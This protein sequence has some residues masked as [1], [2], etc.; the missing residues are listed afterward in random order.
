MQFKD[1]FIIKNY[2]IC[3]EWSY[4]KVVASW[5][6]DGNNTN[7]CVWDGVECNQDT[8]HVIA[9]NLESNCLY[10]SITSSS[11]LLCLLHLQNLTLAY[12]DFNHSQ[13]PS[14]IGNLSSLIHLDLSYSKFSGQIPFEIQYLSKLSFLY[15]VS[16]D[17]YNLYT[18]SLMKSLVQNLT[19][20]E[21]LRFSDLGSYRLYGRF[22]TRIFQLPH[23]LG[24]SA[25]YNEDLTGHLPKFH[26]NS[27]LK[28][29]ILGGTNFSGDLP[30]SIG[31]L[32]SLN[33]FK[34]GNC[35][36]LGTIP[37]SFSNLTHLIELDLSQNSFDDLSWLTRAKLSHLN[38]TKFPDILRNQSRLWYLDLKGNNF[39]G[40]IPKWMFNPECG[41]LKLNVDGSSMGNPGAAGA[42]GVLRDSKGDLLMAFSVHLGTGS[43]NY[44]E[45][46]SLIHGLRRIKMMG[47][48][49][50]DLESDSMMVVRWLKASRCEVWYL[51]EFWEELMEMLKEIEFQ[52]SHIYREGNVAA[53]FLARLGAKGLNKQWL[54]RDI[55]SNLRGIL[56]MDKLE[57]LGR[58]YLSNNFLSGIENSPTIIPWPKLEDLELKNNMMHGSLPIPPPAIWFYSISNNSFTGRISPFICNMSSPLLLDLSYNHLSCMIHPCI[59]NLSQS[60]SV[61]V[62][63]SNNFSSNIP[64]TCQNQ[65]QG[66]LPRSLANCTKHEY[67]HVGHNQINDTYPFWLGTL[68]QL[69]ILVFHSNGFHD[70][71]R[72]PE[73]NYTLPNL[74]IIDLSDNHLSRNLPPGYFTQWDA[75]KSVGAKNLKYLDDYSIDCS[76]IITT[77]GVELEYKKIQDGLTVIDFSCNRFEEDILERLGNLVGLLVLNLSNNAFTGHIPSSFANLTQLESL[78]LS[79][80]KLFG[81]IPPDLTHLNFLSKFNVSHNCLIGLI[82]HGQQFGTFGNTSFEDNRALCGRPLSKIYGD[83]DNS[84]P[85]PSTNFEENQGPK[86]FFEFGWKAVVMGYGCGFVFGVV[87]GHIVITRKQD[88]VI[89]IFGK[90]QHQ[91]RIMVNHRK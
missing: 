25:L 1:S 77:K 47:V 60:L 80:N 73:T 79:Q 35:N 50:I 6:M 53:D 32:N 84:M 22:P 23:L 33:S 39:Q 43:S 36:F 81:E 68:Q 51:E 12:Y 64:K 38:L 8:G 16:F 61:L 67:L 78:D 75:M 19:N 41:R 52:V 15:L 29:L 90:K 69:N 62:L 5:R 45:V 46:M 70:A 14:K 89:K 42:G 20:L 13:I 26:T 30:A 74:H 63:R 18:K 4:P 3:T 56:R 55:P 7:C 91:T 76:I 49:H 34:I 28:Y 21:D 88:W 86:F 11:S 31:N 85:P 27:P 57:S 66:H 37:N 2:S 71:I 59:G 87:I 24:L 48:A 40:L 83:S 72:S 10:G 65:L 82:P 9:L 17:G 54:S 58:L 44:A